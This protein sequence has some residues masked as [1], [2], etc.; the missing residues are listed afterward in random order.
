[1]ANY[2]AYRSMIAIPHLLN[3][4][5]EKLDKVNLMQI[6][7]SEVKRVLSLSVLPSHFFTGEGAPLHSMDVIMGESKSGA[8]FCQSGPQFR[9]DYIQ[10]RTE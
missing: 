7:S 9:K 8:I 10:R 1:M 5:K 4:T 6:L 2:E 3:L